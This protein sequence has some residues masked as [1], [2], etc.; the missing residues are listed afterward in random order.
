MRMT[1]TRL[2]LL[3]LCATSAFARVNES[4]RVDHASWN[5]THV[6]VASEGPQIDGEL[7]VIESWIGDV[8]AGDTIRVPQLVEVERE[9]TEHVTGQRMI[10]FLRRNGETFDCADAEGCKGAVAWSEAGRI[11]A[12]WALFNPGGA[13]LQ[14]FE[15]S[16]E[17]MKGVVRKMRA[18]RKSWDDAISATDCAE[19]ARR[20]QPF[21]KS[22]EM[23]LP[24]EALNAMK[25]CGKG[26]V[27][28]FEETLRDPSLAD[29]HYRV[30][31]TLADIEG[32]DFA[33]ELLTILHRDIAYWKTKGPGLS[34]G[35]WND[36][37]APQTTELR[38][39]YSETLAV[40]EAMRKLKL[41]DARAEVAG[42]RDFWRSYPQLADDKGLAQMSEACDRLLREI[43]PPV[44]TPILPSDNTL[45]RH[46]PHH[47]SV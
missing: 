31:E 29:F 15:T 33:P 19:S 44:T 35:W 6:V 11:F 43:P 32:S 41:T 45:S 2:L 5:A 40:I 27:P 13:S 14:D 25:A 21:L 10:L 36:V 46:A 30:I 39:V 3:L 42:F 12:Y 9:T 22:K 28:V 24:W 1:W 17:A 7:T 20:L 4:L 16:E 23:Q 26:A 18:L 8:A 37:E 34:Q 38:N 47:H